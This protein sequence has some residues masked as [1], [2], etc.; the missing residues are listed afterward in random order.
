[1]EEVPVPTISVARLL[2]KHSI[3]KITLLQID[4]EG[5]DFEILKMFLA[6]QALP[7]VVNFE[8]VNLSFRD[9][10]DSG[11]LLVEHGY[12]FIDVGIDTLAIRAS[13]TKSSEP[14]T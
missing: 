7:D 12:R 14:E 10:Q 1:M 13:I 2:Q 3:S 8:R 5:Y 11:L 9:R 6:A 4:T